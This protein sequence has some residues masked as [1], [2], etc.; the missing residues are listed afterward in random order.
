MAMPVSEKPITPPA[1]KAVLKERVHPL[2]GSHAPTV[3][4]ALEKTATRMPMKPETIEVTAPTKKESAEMRPDVHAHSPV[5]GSLVAHEMRRVMPTET[6]AT[7]RA[8]SLYSA[9]RKAEAPTVMARYSS[10]SLVF[11][12]AESAVRVAPGAEVTSRRTDATWRRRKIEKTM[13]MMPVATMMG[14]VRAPLASGSMPPLTHCA[15][16]RES[17]V[18]G[19][20]GVSS[21]H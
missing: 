10:T 13:P 20:H 2:E 11:C 12:S 5:A 15:M 3:Q 21:V 14:V 6:T 1:R 4:R 8:Q 18:R 9:L 19:C 7:K 17:M 16:S